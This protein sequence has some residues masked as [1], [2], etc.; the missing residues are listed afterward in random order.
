MIDQNRMSRAECPTGCATKTSVRFVRIEHE[1][2]SRLDGCRKVANGEVRLVVERVRR[3]KLDVTSM[4]L[5]HDLRSSGALAP[6]CGRECR[7]SLQNR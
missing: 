2:C 6:A 1:A 3:M 4:W 5:I 7:S